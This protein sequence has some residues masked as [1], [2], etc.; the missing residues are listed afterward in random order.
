[1]SDNI[2]KNPYKNIIAALYKAE[3]PT[4]MVFIRRY[5]RYNSDGPVNRL[6]YTLVQQGLIQ[7]H[8]N[9]GERKKYSLTEEGLLVYDL[10]IK[11][12]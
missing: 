9:P 6:F 4:T 7:I 3:K 12:K 5:V 1:M 11:K 2:I 10:L 8:E